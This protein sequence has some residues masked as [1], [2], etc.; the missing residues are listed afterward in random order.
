MKRTII[1]EIVIIAIIILLQ[2]FAGEWYSQNIYPAISAILSTLTSIIPFSVGDFA[3][4]T[5]TFSLLILIFSFRTPII[6]RLS[7][8][9]AIVLGVVICFY[10]SWGINY[11]RDDIYSRTKIE[12]RQHSNEEFKIFAD[13]FINQMNT[14]Y[15]KYDSLH[16]PNYESEI[17]AAYDNLTT[18]FKINAPTLG[19]HKPMI[20]SALMMKLGVSGYFNPFFGEYHINNDLFNV[21]KPSTFAHEAAHKA[22]ITSEAEANLMA[23]LICSDSDTPNIQF[24]GYYGVLSYILSSAYSTLG[25]EALQELID[26]INPE[27]ITLKRRESAYYSEKYSE[28]LGSAQSYIYDKFLKANSIESGR[29]SYGE[30]VG[31]LLD[32]A[33]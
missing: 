20:S 28:T 27:I 25:K 6:K 32:F 7:Y 26:T 14:S 9:L 15:S 3:V 11:F 29:G 24:S 22:G 8:I 10:A 19:S 30:V 5:L 18:K 13:R 17:I 12:K 16:T 33:N 1:V 21:S 31:L 2:Q 4:V 23:Y